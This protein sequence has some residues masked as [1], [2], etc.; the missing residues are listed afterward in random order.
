MI[1]KV[2]QQYEDE[3]LDEWLEAASRLD[4]TTPELR[5]ERRRQAQ[6]F[7]QQLGS[8]MDDHSRPEDVRSEPWAGVRATLDTIVDVHLE[9]GSNPADIAFFV[10]SVKRPL[11][12]VILRQSNDEETTLRHLWRINLIVDR[13]GLYTAEVQIRRK[14]QVIERQQEEILELSSPVVQ[15]WDGVLAVPLIGTLDSYR[16]QQVTETILEAVVATRSEQVILDITGVPTV[17]TQVAHH[18]LKTVAALRLMGAEAIVSGIRPQIA[19]TM[20]HLGVDLGQVVTKARLADALK[21]A[22]QRGGLLV[23]SG[24]AS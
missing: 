15:V 8:S 16:T 4:Q 9:E 10:L 22:F 7:L 2:I 14:Q 12:R 19:Q 3:L 18:L 23:S 5:D 6:A 21:L 1:A 11:F 13:L 24:A 20:V 17:D